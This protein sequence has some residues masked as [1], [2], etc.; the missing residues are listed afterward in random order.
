MNY[1]GG[2]V[3]SY[4]CKLIQFS[5]PNSGAPKMFSRYALGGGIKL[6]VLGLAAIVVLVFQVNCFFFSQ[7]ASKWPTVTGTITSSGVETRR[8]RGRRGR[9]S[10][11]KRAVVEYRYFAGG[12]QH[13]NDRVRVTDKSKGFRIAQWNSQAIV[14]EYPTGTK[15]TV[16]Y[17]PDEP[18]NS[19]LETA[20]PMSSYIWMLGSIVALAI[21]CAFLFG[22]ATPS[23]SL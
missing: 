15:V 10:T 19:V 11:S 7:S 9:P 18:S 8:T 13:T 22:A 12:K 23:N 21:S 1:D 17:D 16:A 4:G 20:L 6:M 14:D 5:F 2:F 3:K